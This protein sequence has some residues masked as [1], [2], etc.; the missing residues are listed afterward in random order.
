MIGSLNPIISREIALTYHPTPKIGLKKDV[1]LPFSDQPKISR[2]KSQLFFI[3]FYFF[4]ILNF[5]LL[6][7]N[8]KIKCQNRTVPTGLNQFWSSVCPRMHINNTAFLLRPD[9]K[10]KEK[11]IDLPTLPIFRPKWQTNLLLFRPHVLIPSASHAVVGYMYNSSSGW[12][13]TDKFHHLD[14]SLHK[15]KFSTPIVVVVVVWAHW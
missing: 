2:K 11:I 14:F 10:K 8:F 3:I 1:C 5:A 12:L 9:L 4:F 6:N 15:T 13:E 7:R